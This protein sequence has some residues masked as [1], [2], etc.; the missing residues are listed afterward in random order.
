MELFI[1]ALLAAAVAADAGEQQKASS[2]PK[3]PPPREPTDDEERAAW[4]WGEIGYEVAFWNQLQEGMWLVGRL[5]CPHGHQNVT[6]GPFHVSMLH[7]LTIKTTPIH[8]D[9]PELWDEA[10][11][12]Y[13]T[14]HTDI[15]VIFECTHHEHEIGKPDD[16]PGY[17]FTAPRAVI[18][19]LK[20]T[21][22]SSA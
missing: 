6:G 3:L 15:P 21:P 16:Y 22:G 2:I 4:W 19:A 17:L 8:R 5:T 14:D 11:D 10:E 20:T 12:W 7:D 9:H 13:D 18:E 1:L